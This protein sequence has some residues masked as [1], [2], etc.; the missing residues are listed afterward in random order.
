[1]EKEKL[2]R[3]IEDISEFYSPTSGKKDFDYYLIKFSVEVIK[4]FLIGEDVLELGC[5]KGTSTFLLS[6][7]CKKITVVEA[8]QNNIRHAK[9]RV[10]SKKKVK[11]VHSLWEDFYPQYKFTDVIASGVLE[12]CRDPVSLLKKIRTWIENRGRIHIV[13]PN[14]HSLHR[15]LG[16]YMGIIKDVH[17]LHHRDIQM[18]HF[19]V[20]DRDLLFKDIQ[21]AGLKVYHWEGIFLKPFPNDR[22]LHL[23]KDI[24]EGLYKLGKEFPQV[25]AEIYVCCTR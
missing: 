9:R 16:V 5:A 24:I 14:A 12:H 22:M 3:R 1:M 18:G 17:Q 10:K 2:L 25:C 23:P 20:Y 15:K 4:K 11:F 8:S 19:R 7:V 6:S 13:V 21:S